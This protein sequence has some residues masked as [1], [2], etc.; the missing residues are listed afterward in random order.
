[1]TAI[2][3]PTARR[4]FFP[5]RGLPSGRAV[6]GAL[7]VTLAAVGAFATA[8]AADSGPTSE[9]LVLLHDIE[10][11]DSVQA[12]DVVSMALDLSPTIA[13]HA[14]RSPAGLDGATALSHL[15]EGSLL[16]VRDLNG[17]PFI[18]GEPVVSIHELTIPVPRDRAP[19]SLRRGDRVT[20]LAYA[21]SDGIVRTALEDALVLSFGQES[22]GVGSSDTARLT[23]GLNEPVAVAN[24]TLWSY[25]ALTVVLTTGAIDDLY[26]AEAAPPTT[27]PIHELE[28]AT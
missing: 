25:Q 14:L 5:R 11:G 20:V 26:P 15:H 19:A 6:V 9:Y 17:A 2:D 13:T 16:D 24:A 18:D 23:L 8:T 4:S 21:A 10:A 3:S 28:S 7:L 1:M 22:A 27:V 12:R